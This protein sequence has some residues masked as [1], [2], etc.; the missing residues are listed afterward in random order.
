[1]FRCKVRDLKYC[2][3]SLGR[4]AVSQLREWCRGATEEI[5]EGSSV[6]HH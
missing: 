6:F 3:L 1:M 2:F 5:T 4:S